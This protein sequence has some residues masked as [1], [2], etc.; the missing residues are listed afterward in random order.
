[1]DVVVDANFILSQEKI[2]EK[3]YERIGKESNRTNAATSPQ[4]RGVQQKRTRL[5]PLS[6]RIR[7]ESNREMA[8]AQHRR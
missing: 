1:M 3:I 4:K 2:Q 8:R 7:A 5:H 6:L